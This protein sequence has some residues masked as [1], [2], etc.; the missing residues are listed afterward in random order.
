MNFPLYIAKRYL[1]S[2]KSTNVINLISLISVV[3]VAVG[4][5]ALIVVLSVFNGFDELITDLYYSF[6]ADLQITVKSGKTFTID[7]KIREQIKSNTAI[8]CFSEIVEENALIKHKDK[9]YIATIRGVNSN[10]TK[11]NSIEKYIVEGE[12]VLKNDSLNF[13]VVGQGVAYFLSMALEYNM[14]TLSFYV[15]KRNANIETSPENAFNKKNISAVGVFQIQSEF[16]SKYVIVPIDFARDLFGYKNEISSIEMRIKN[17]KDVKMVQNQLKQLLGN[18][19]EVKD[20]YEQNE[21]LFKIMKSEKW[22]IFLIL[23]FILIIASF[24]IIGSLTMLI[25]DKQQDIYILRGLG[26]NYKTIRNIFLLEG[27]MI[28]FLGAIL[29]TILGITICYIQQYFGIIKLQGSGSFVIEN[30]PVVVDYIDVSLVFIVVLFIGFIASWYPVRYIT[31]K[32]VNQ[33]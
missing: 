25:I 13:A 14:P 8:D 5:M 2:K 3:G 33:K 16:D 24:N 9:Q 20:K 22:A 15:P 23:T 27:W 26:A 11:I 21:M 6:N 19:F 28:S 17:P 31:R 7:D 30:Y 12:Y 10:Y 1:L 29:G 18:N 4:T 32:F